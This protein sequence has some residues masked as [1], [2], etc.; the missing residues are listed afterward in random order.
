MVR[1]PLLALFFLEDD[2][3]AHQDTELTSESRAYDDETLDKWFSLIGEGSMNM[4]WI[5]DASHDSPAKP[6]GHVSLNTLDYSGDRSLASPEDHRVTFASFFIY[7]ENRGSGMGKAVVREVER[8]AKEDMGAKE[9]TINT[10][11]DKHAR[12][13]ECALSL[14]VLTSSAYTQRCIVYAQHGDK[15]V[16][17]INHLA[18]VQRR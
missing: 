14:A 15:P 16:R 10:M 18:T 11:S 6:I 12:N 4:Y 13:T 3:D 7:R 8:R 9:I 5:F 1:T 17:A 2:L